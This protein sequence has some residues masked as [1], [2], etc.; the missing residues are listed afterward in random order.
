M[1]IKVDRRRGVLD[2][3][4]EWTAAAMDDWAEWERQ[5]RDNLGHGSTSV[6]WRLMQAKEIGVASHGTSIEPEMPDLIAAVDAAVAKLVRHEKRAFRTYYLTYATIADKARRC[7]C[8]TPEFYRRLRRA[9][10]TVANSLQLD[11]FAV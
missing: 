4:P 7:R 2:D 6:A 8:S 3:I 10:R 1:P 9:R 11:R 5:H